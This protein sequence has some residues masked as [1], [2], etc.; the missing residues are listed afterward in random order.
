MDEYLE[1][2]NECK[3]KIQ[4]IKEEIHELEKLFATSITATTTELDSSTSLL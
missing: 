2:V 1:K 4:K 3:T